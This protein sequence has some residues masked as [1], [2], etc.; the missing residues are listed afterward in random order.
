[1]LEGLKVMQCGKMSWVFGEFLQSILSGT[2]DGFLV[3][4]LGKLWGLKRISLVSSMVIFSRCVI[5][6]GFGS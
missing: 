6:G 3:Q 2:S 4:P 1:M 5:T